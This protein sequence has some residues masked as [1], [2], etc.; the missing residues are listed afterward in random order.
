MNPSDYIYVGDLSQQHQRALR[1]FVS[2]YRKGAADH[3]DLERNKK[4]T[5]E[6][7]DEGCDLAFYVIFELLEMEDSG[8]TDLSSS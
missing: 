4:W 6:M 1:Y 8:G 3:G 5:R 2:K 7:L